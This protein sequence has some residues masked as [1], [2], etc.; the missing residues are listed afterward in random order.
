MSYKHLAPIVLVI[1][2]LVTG[3]PAAFGNTYYIATDGSDSN[4]GSIG[5]PFASIPHALSLLDGS[6]GHSIYVRGG[7]YNL[8]TKIDIDLGGVS[9]NPNNLWAYP[10]E[11]PIFN[12]A[13][14]SF[15]SS[16]RGFELGDAANW[17]YLK[18]L[19][20][21]NAGDNGLN[22]VADNGIFEQLVTRYNRDSGLQLHGTA[23]N[24]LV[25]N[26]DSYENF[27]A[28]TAGEN[29]DG[30][31]AKFN[32]L[33]VGNVF[34][35]DRAWA[36]SDDG[37][38]TW[39]SANGVLMD[40]C[41]SFDNGFNIWGVGGFAGDGTG[42][43]LGTPGGDHVL[44][45]VLAVDNANNGVDVNGNGTGVQVY[46][47][48]SYSNSGKNWQFD[49]NLAAHIL[50]NNVSYA[51]GSSDNIYPLVSDSYNTWNGIPVDS[52]DFQ[53]LTRV[54]ASVDLLKAPRQADGS[55]PDLGGYL[56]LVDGSNLVDAGTPISFTFD[57]VPYS[58]PYNDG[59]PDLGAFETGI[60][61]PALPGDYN[62]DGMVDAADYT[63]W[64]DNLN[65]SAELPN[66]ETPGEVT[67]GDYTVW[68]T[69]FGESLGSGSLVSGVAVPEPATA[70]LLLLAAGVLLLPG[71]GR[72]R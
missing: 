55:L 15:G 32:G 63:V 58:L 50:K 62:D 28:P 35:G 41:W 1:L 60:V 17:W 14:Q 44:S 48:T 34:R 12:F 70:V 51:G 47:A 71:V 57:G 7:T 3:L 6:G 8:S 61:P 5:S 54:V 23:T 30:F 46:N 29:A 65:T 4:D 31:A 9:G 10:G 37:W 67:E 72:C 27:D 2:S 40:N 33:G 11:T 66:D 45:N 21:Q 56:H 42:Y 26:C 43:K 25:L 36:N 39:D 53:S 22:T 13:G 24:N 20:I 38:D 18:G 49:E 16:N 69:H 52:A 59:A 64:R 68:K 19:T